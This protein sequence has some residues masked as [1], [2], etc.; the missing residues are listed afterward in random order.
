M[1]IAY[2]SAPDDS[3]LNPL[4]LLLTFGKP[5]EACSLREQPQDHSCTAGIARDICNDEQKIHTASKGDPT[6]GA[7]SVLEIPQGI[8]SP[9]LLDQ[10][11]PAIEFRPTRPS[12]GCRY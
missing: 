7:Q 4:F 3:D 11:L 1:D 10:I 12:E 6:G 9:G 5:L 2:Q 8:F